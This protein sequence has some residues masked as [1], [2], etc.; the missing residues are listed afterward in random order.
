MRPAELLTRLVTWARR[1]R[2]E[3]QVDEELTSHVELLARD[4]QADGL[5]ADAAL[6]E[7]KRRVGHSL[8]QREASRDAWGFPGIDALIQ[9]V[10]F[11]IRGLRRSPGFTIAAVVTLGLGI[12]ANAAMFAV[13]DRLM[14]RPL[15]YLRDPGDVGAVYLQITPQGNRRIYSTIPYT[16]YLDLV[17]NTHTIAEYAAVSEWRLAVGTGDATRIRKVAGIS[18]STWSM[19]T[20]RP[21][22]GRFFGP[23]DDALPLGNQ[24][25]VLSHAYWRSAFG[26]SDVIGRRIKIGILEY[27]IIGVA[28]SGF[29]G[30]SG[31]GP[32]EIFVP[33]T[34]IPATMGPWAK[35]TYYRDYRWDWTDVLVRPKPGVSKAVAAADLGEA[36]RRSR[37][38]QRELVPTVLPDSVAHPSAIVGSV[39]PAA[40]PDAGMESRILLW[41][42]G[43]AV[44][45]LLIAS[46][47]VANLVLAR[48]LGR[49]REIA[50][51]IALGVS[52]A[53][54]AF[55]FV[56]ESLVLAAL[57]IVAAIVVAQFVGT[58]V[59]AMLLPEGT[60]FNL[61][62]DPR[63][64]A[65]AIACASIAV[66]ITV[67]A[68]MSIARS[69]NLVGGL[70]VGARDGG[71]RSVRLRSMLLV[72]QG[73]LSVALLVGAALFVRSLQNVLAIPLGFDLSQVVDVYPDFRGAKLDSGESV[74]IRRRLLATAQAIPGVTA[75]TRVN[76][77]V[78]ATNTAQLRVIGIDS[79]EKLGRFN[80]Q[81]A[82]PDY[83]KVM[84]TRILRGRSFTS[85]DVDGAARVAIVS[86]SMAKKLWPDRDA[87]GQCLF[88][89]W[90]ASPKTP[91]SQVVGVA[92]DVAAQ[93]LMDEERLMYYVPVEQMDAAGA[94]SINV[95]LSGN[96]VA[97]G[98]ERVRAAMQ[99]VMPGDG[100]VVVTALQ[101][102]VDEQRRAWRL[103]AT[104]FLAFGGLA[105]IVA[106]VGLYGVTAYNVAQ[107]MHELGVRIALGAGSARI[108]GM[109]LRAALATTG[110]AIAIGLAMALVGSRWL[111]PLLY[112]QS[113]RDPLVY[114]GVALG[115][116]AVTIAAASVPARRAMRADPNRA[117]RAD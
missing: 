99:A 103:G 91:C 104:L 71:T 62:D 40:G 30:A 64:L 46:A 81:L 24:V 70:K 25:A 34:T 102:R 66:L 113:P 69:A 95:R 114:A 28:P 112:R 56:S 39:R 67:V 76:S 54:L 72:V 3:A 105:A 109:V 42:A 8:A 38:K 77:P 83:F 45:V 84:G 41:V 22:I 37:A 87:L 92:E 60:P 107:R 19:F 20:A 52:R 23:A 47:N 55:Q 51:R 90:E 6:A 68:P 21:V 106:A 101:R 98:V 29:V 32:P 2:L 12:G 97:A 85:G 35:D 116:I 73:A 44:I 33:I 111:E 27:S 17:A 61:A 18:A 75:A 115:M 88:V 53:R 93:R 7:A 100:F 117:L 59:R 78:F 49:R 43:V 1:D 9:D 10:R 94:S 89:A 80:I 26:G 86:Q 14:F 48:T 36:Y 31:G 82:S 5:S 74:A 4:L 13:I 57:G 79:V 11:A 58:G 65:V 108:M 16:R 63:T 50:L 15:P 110:I 96:E